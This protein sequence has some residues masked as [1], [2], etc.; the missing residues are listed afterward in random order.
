MPDFARIYARQEYLTPGA[1]ETVDILAEAVKPSEK[2]VLLDVGSGKGEAAATLASHH[3]CRVLCVEPF[4]PFVHYSAAKFWHF[5]LRDLVNLIRGNGRRLPLR[6]ASV[7]AAYCI[8]GPSIVGLERCLLE[9]ARVVRPGGAVIVSDLTWRD[10]PGQLDP[11]WRFLATAVQISREEY[12]DMLAGAG[13]IVERFVTHGRPAWEEYWRPMLEVAAEAKT[14][15]PADVFFADE[16]EAGAD[17]ERRAIELWLEY[18]TFV[19][20]K[21]G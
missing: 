13:L 20:R 17:M 19:S 2:T 15:Q 8:G 5:N 6:D 11:S 3:A 7:D 12:A 4:D 1:P 16:I 14:A 21:P 10:K 18:T 9:M